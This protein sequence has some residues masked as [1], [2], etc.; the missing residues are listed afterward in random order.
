[1]ARETN[2]R[3]TDGSDG[4]RWQSLAVGALLPFVALALLFQLGVPLGRPGRFVYLYS[5]NVGWR[6]DAIPWALLI[7]V[8]LAAGV[9]LMF[10]ERRGRRWAG[11]AV[12]VGGAIALGC[13]SYLAPPDHVAQHV[14]NM[15]SP[16]H[17]GA[18]VT[19][20]LEMD[21]DL[22]RYLS[23]Y[24]ER[25][26]TPPEQMRGTRVISN[27]PG[28]TLLA[29][30]LRRCV[31]PQAAWDWLL[32]ERF[33]REKWEDEALARDE[34]A[35][36]DF[37]Q[38][39]TVGLA[40]CWALTALWLLA[41]PLFYAV[42]RLYFQ[43]APAAAFAVCCLVTPAT[44]L[45]TPGKDPGQLATVALPLL[46]WLLAWRR[47]AWLLAAASGVAF[48]G[49]CMVGVIHAWTAAVVAGASLLSARHTPNGLRRLLARGFGPAILGSV[50]AIGVLY[51][52][53]GLNV[54]ATALAVA[55]TQAEVTRGPDAMPVVW[56]L[57]GIPLFMLFAGPALWTGTLW[58][59]TRSSVVDTAR[60][61]HR[62]FGMYLV[63]CCLLALAATAA[64]T[65]VET[66]RLWM[67][68][69]P[70][71]LLGI[72]L[73]LKTFRQ[74]ARRDVLPLVTLVLA[75]V[76]FSALQWAFMDM[77]EAETRLLTGEF[78]W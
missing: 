7:G 25:A 61:E 57:I 1:M 78:F 72:A 31:N 62:R 20:A 16:S 56:Q 38:H 66:P 14:F 73:G 11:A 59:V 33:E 32:R 3:S 40:F 26:R 69:A 23:S 6:L 18:F 71:L 65:N 75:Q 55:R 74:P 4:R 49:A 17:D 19:E 50:L 24:P 51:V 15:S 70:L 54:P 27:P 63:V 77:R 67:P 21:G 9:W 22:R 47:G 60:D 48:V 37:R 2:N 28:M 39:A 35:L 64:F 5:Q 68:F 41:G 46:L 34:V 8:A 30:A 13:W 42:G 12:L 53:C 76:A 43:P 58:R 44:L 10:G 36:A 52:C 29:Y 45:F